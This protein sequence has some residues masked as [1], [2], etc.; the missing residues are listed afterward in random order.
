MGEEII[1]D[2]QERMK[3]IEDAI[4][5]RRRGI[6]QD[7]QADEAPMSERERAIHQINLRRQKKDS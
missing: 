7:D 4:F 5:Q 2:R 6:N 1:D 3:A